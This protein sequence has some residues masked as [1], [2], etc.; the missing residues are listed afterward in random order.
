MLGSKNRILSLFYKYS[1]IEA[2]GSETTQSF[3]S[4]VILG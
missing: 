3:M 2:I 1:K 4:K